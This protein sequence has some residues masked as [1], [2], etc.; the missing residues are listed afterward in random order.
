MGAVE[1][2]IRCES[3]KVH[4]QKE[5]LWLHKLV[6]EWTFEG[7]MMEPGKP[8]EKFDGT[9]SVRLLGDIWIIAEGHVKTPEGCPGTTMMTLGYSPE[10]GRF[11]GTFIGTM[12]TH[13][14]LYDGALDENEKS[15]VLES[16]GPDMSGEGKMWQFRDVIE[17]ED[18]DHRTM[19]SYMLDDDGQWRELM[20]THYRR[21]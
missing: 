3:M 7:S 16:Y 19:R 12:M 9:E 13:L 2:D 14:W 18:D 17:F 21:R 1:T 11:V 4:P 10:K 5:H 20:K 8:Q 15:L 6:G